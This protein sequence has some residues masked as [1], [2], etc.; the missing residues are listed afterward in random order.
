MQTD[1]ETAVI[2]KIGFGMYSFVFFI[3]YVT[4]SVKIENHWTDSF[5]KKSSDI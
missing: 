2:Q 1:S 5:N 4:F 3:L